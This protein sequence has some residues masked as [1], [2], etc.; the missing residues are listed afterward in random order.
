MGAWILGKAEEGVKRGAGGRANPAGG[1]WGLSRL[2]EGEDR[3]C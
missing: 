1:S 2:K 3:V